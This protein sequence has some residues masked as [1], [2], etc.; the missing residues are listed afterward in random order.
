MKLVNIKEKLKDKEILTILAESIYMPTK[1]KLNT[2]AEKYRNDDRIVGQRKK[3]NEDVSLEYVLWRLN[4]IEEICKKKKMPS[5][6]KAS[7]F[8]YIVHVPKIL[9]RKLVLYI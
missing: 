5:K 6:W 2:R 7:S 1:E 3:K 9:C 4:I 8:S